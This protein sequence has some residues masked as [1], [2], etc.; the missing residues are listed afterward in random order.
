MGE[1]RIRA[2]RVRCSVID[3]GADDLVN[4]AL[5]F[6]AFCLASS[7]RIRLQRLDG[8]RS[9]PRSSAEKS[10]PIASGALTGRTVALLGIMTAAAAYAIA[11]LLGPAM[12]F[13]D[14]GLFRPQHRIRVWLKH[15]IIAD[16]FAIAGRIPASPARR[17]GRARDTAVALAAALRLCADRCCWRWASGAGSS[18]TSGHNRKTRSVLGEY[19]LPLLDQPLGICATLTLAALRASIRSVGYGRC[20][21]R[22]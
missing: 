20:A 22:R 1:E 4:A 14:L 5:A 13:P 21:P 16:V 18:I 11:L 2:G 12:T 6:I 8:P 19:S 17:N 15:V 3:W 7:A 10:R 9:R